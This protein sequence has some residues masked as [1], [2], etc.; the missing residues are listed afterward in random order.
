MQTIYI[1]EVHGIYVYSITEVN[2]NL[3][4]FMNM[5]RNNCSIYVYKISKNK[6]HK[7]CRYIYP[8][9]PLSPKRIQNIREF[10]FKIYNSEI[11]ENYIKNNDIVN[12]FE[13]DEF[14]NMISYIYKDKD[15]DKEKQTYSKLDK[16]LS[17][18]FKREN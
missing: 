5:W 4:Y 7:V 8:K 14:G 2:D 12:S 18:S 13:Y 16:I 3:L 1:V 6:I 10:D 11:S 15:K 9:K 17:L